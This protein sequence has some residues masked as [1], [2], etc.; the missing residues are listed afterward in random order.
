MSRVRS[1]NA[2]RQVGSY[3]VDGP[4]RPPEPLPDPLAGEMAAA[5]LVAVDH[6]RARLAA[7]LP[8]AALDSA[9]QYFEAPSMRVWDGG[10]RPE[11][12]SADLFAEL[13]AVPRSVSVRD[14]AAG[15]QLELRSL[16]E[17]FEMEA[18]G[19]PV[20]PGSDVLVLSPA[21]LAAAAA[22]NTSIE[23]R[24][25]DRQCPA[26]APFADDL[27][28]VTGADIFLKLFVADGN[29][30]VNGWHRDASD[31]LVTLIHGAKRF[32]IA[33]STP[34]EPDEEPKPV[35]DAVLRVG[36]AL[37][38]PRAM[39]HRATP[40]G[41]LSA[42]L[43]IGLMRVGDWPFRQVPPTHLGFRDYPRSARAYR[44]CLRSH[45]PPTPSARWDPMTT[46][47][48]T[49]VPGGIAVLDI[50]GTEVSFVTA[51]TVYEATEPLVRILGRI[52]AADGISASDVAE[53]T[54]IPKSSC[55]SVIDELLAQSL[56]RI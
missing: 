36:D 46:P 8:A 14:K 29:R 37:R 13:C 50:R 26:W 19:D 43:S 4:R 54:G 53:A 33:A 7:R 10:E 25:F 35:I 24:Q 2:L 6:A 9:Y 20:E 47:L 34:A 38:L 52:H 1:S 56:I 41:D 51:G 39:L 12:A 42:L 15:L 23:L 21:R 55:I 3:A 40:D 27:A 30:S 48:R 18:L 11:L 5:V 31:V 44:L 45:V 32:E 16:N 49:R 22:R 28:A 17:A